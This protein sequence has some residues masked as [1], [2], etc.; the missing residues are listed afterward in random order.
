MHWCKITIVKKKESP[1]EW[2]GITLSLCEP[3]SQGKK[4]QS[5]NRVRENE[6][7]PSL[8]GFNVERDHILPGTCESPQRRRTRMDSPEDQR[9]R[10]PENTRD[11]P[12]HWCWCSRTQM[13]WMSTGYFRTAPCR[14][15]WWRGQN[16]VRSLL[17]M[18]FPVRSC[19]AS[20]GYRNTR[21]CEA[22][23]SRRSTLYW[24]M[25][26]RLGRR[27]TVEPNLRRCEAQSLHPAQFGL[28]ERQ[29]RHTSARQCPHRSQGTGREW[30]IDHEAWSG[31]HQASTGV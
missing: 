2:S 10:V 13:V 17:R 25:E 5:I 15:S 7:D 9:S 24:T 18:D 11:P 31:G 29:P 20:R 19:P 21:A 4:S 30:W 3:A 14:Q 12:A 23:P 28:F 26:Q 16:Q 6:I 1:K 27:G 22:R 8:Q